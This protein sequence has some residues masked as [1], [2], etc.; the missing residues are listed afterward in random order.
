MGW[1]VD[2]CLWHKIKNLIQYQYIKLKRYYTLYGMSFKA[3]VACFKKKI[4][5]LTGETL[6]KTLFR[7]ACINNRLDMSIDW[8]ENLFFS[9][10]SYSCFKR[11]YYFE[12]QLFY[13]LL[14]VSQLSIEIEPNLKKTDSFCENWKT[15]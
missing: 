13:W 1:C 8:Y 15:R 5:F 4:I 10:L 7:Q 12:N 14:F 9:T 3:G 11:H 2:H 6:D